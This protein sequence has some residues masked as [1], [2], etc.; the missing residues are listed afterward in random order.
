[1]HR[2][3]DPVEKRKLLFRHIDLTVRSDVRLDAGEDLQL[4]IPH[5]HLLD[6][7]ELLREPSVAQVM[8]VVGDPVVLVAAIE[9]GDDHLLQRVLAVCRPVSVR[10]QIAA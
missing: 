1:V 2:S 9:R 10:M 3:N 5:A 7:F 4:R 8:R 6:L